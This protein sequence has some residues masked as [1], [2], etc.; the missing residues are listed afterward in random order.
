MSIPADRPGSAASA[1]RAATLRIKRGERTLSEVPLG[2]ARLVVGGG[3]GA[4]LRLKNAGLPDECLVLDLREEVFHVESLLEADDVRVNGMMAVGK[5][6]IEPGDKVEF[7]GITLEILDAEGRAVPKK[8]LL[9]RKTEREPDDPYMGKRTAARVTMEELEK[10]ALNAPGAKSPF[11]RERMLNAPTENDLSA[12]KPAAARG[13]DTLKESDGVQA[14]QVKARIDAPTQRELPAAAPFRK[15]RGPPVG[16]VDLPEPTRSQEIPI[17]KPAVAAPVARPPWLELLADDGSSE[18]RLFID[19]SGITAG[20]QGDLKIQHASVSKKHA[21]F[22]LKGG[23]LL[24]E[25]LGSTNGTWINRERIS[26]VRELKSGDTLHLGAVEFRVRLPGAKADA[27]NVSPPPPPQPSRDIS[28]EISSGSTNAGLQRPTERDLPLRAPPPAPEVVRRMEVEPSDPPLLVGTAT[29]DVPVRM[30][31]KAKVE[32]DDAL[33][34]EEP[35][36]IVTPQPRKSPFRDDAPTLDRTGD[37]RRGKSDQFKSP[38]GQFKVAVRPPD[39]ILPPP[40]ASRGGALFAIGSLLI[41][42]AGTGVGGWLAW[43]RVQSMLRAEPT[44]IAMGTPAPRNDGGRSDGGKARATPGATPDGRLAM[45]D[46]RDRDRE[47][48]KGGNVGAQPTPSDDGFVND[49]MATPEPTPE[50]RPGRDMFEGLDVK[51]DNRVDLARANL[52]KDSPNGRLRQE[53][54]IGDAELK[55]IFLDEGTAVVRSFDPNLGFDMA[56]SSYDEQD[57]SDRKLGAKQLDPNKVNALIRARFG[58]VRRC[59]VGSSGFK[60]GKARVVVQ[61]TINPDGKISSLS[62]PQSDI[63]GAKFEG[64]VTSVIRTIKFPKPKE[65]SVVVQ[66]PFVFFYQ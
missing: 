52:E 65:Q 13:A 41:L 33:L 34:D 31:A 60:N 23:T 55:S 7:F 18:S 2:R 57:E 14:A 64:C 1:A 28:K 30:R 9:Y 3:K 37:H 20:R 61:F 66:F 35:L 17:P 58:D 40:R 54:K 51:G 27:T 19:R 38:S 63:K 42:I 44:P 16:A 36:D 10:K 62:V 49:L 59:L 5:T 53:R 46:K 50:A 24:V 6:T 26:S 32:L 39:P 43:P 47:R 8:D 25:D 12:P 45:T 48:L 22:H 56:P 11:N 15:R 29:D 21:A 4:Q